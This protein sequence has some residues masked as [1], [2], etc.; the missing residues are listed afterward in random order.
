MTHTLPDGFT[1]RPA[2]I[3]D[4]ECVANLVNDQ[5]ESVG[6]GRPT[7]PERVRRNWDHPQFDLATDS[8]LVF[9]PDGAL[10]GFAR[11]RDV[12]DPP[13]DVFGGFVVHPGHNGTAWLWDDLFDWMEAE[14]RR[15]IPKAPADARIAL[16]AGAPETDRAEQRELERH[17][18]D[19]S[20]TWHLMQIDFT[21]ESPAHREEPGL[22]PEGIGV[23]EF[24]PGSDDE[25]LVTAW[26]EAFANHYGIVSQPFETELE[27][28]R[29][30]MREDDF[31]PSLWFL[32]YDCDDST[33]VGLC[34]CHATAPGDPDRAKI[35]DVG[36]RP[37]WRRRG[38]GRA[39]L[40]HAFG[41]LAER[42]IE[43]AILTVDTENKSGAP[44]L[45]E[46]VGMRSV[47]ANHTYVKELRPGVNLVAG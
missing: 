5:S 16:V 35:G 24:V 6:R 8:R 10:I 46:G 43:G 31:D 38:I 11:I 4:A 9:A 32:A 17:G 41:A 15:V 1:A 13:V 30:L 45:Y 34:I 26:C 2:T 20:R 25:A 27:E 37:P 40:L 22:W 47:R 21:S 14:A 19:H 36:V 29:Q 12:K 23:R 39:L 18:F 3:G 28:W 44:A 42:G 33:V 7:T